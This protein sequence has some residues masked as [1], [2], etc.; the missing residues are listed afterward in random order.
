MI[1]LPNYDDQSFQSIMERATGC[2]PVIYPQWTDLNEHDPGITILELFAWLKEMQQFQLNRISSRS[3]ASLLKLLGVTVRGPVPSETRLGFA[4]FSGELTLLRGA[5]FSTQDVVFEAQA[6][7]DLHS[8]RVEH[9]YMSDGNVFHNVTDMI[10]EPS[11]YCQVFG[12]APLEG[13]SALYIGLNGWAGKQEL[14]LYFQMDDSYPVPR[15]PFREDVLLPREIAWEYGVTGEG[16]LEF[17]VMANVRDETWGFSQSGHVVFSMAQEPAPGSPGEGLPSCCWLR[18][19]LVRQGCEENPRLLNIFTDTLPVVQKETHCEMT[20]YTFDP[21]APEVLCEPDSRLVQE[22]EAMVFVR[23][24]AGWQIHDRVEILPD[25]RGRGRVFKLNLPEGM[26][27][28]GG[29][30]VRILCYEPSFKNAMLL[31]GSDG[32]PCQRFPFR[33]QEALLKEQLRLMV[34]EETEE[35]QRGWTDWSYSHNLTLAGPYDR[36]FTYDS[37]RGELV[38]GDNEHGAV[39][40]AGEDN[41]LITDCAVTK[42]NGGN[43]GYQDFASLDDEA[44]S[45]KPFNLHPVRGGRDEESLQAAL[46]R[47]Q[48]SLKEC[49]RAVTATDYETLAMGTPGRRIMGAKAI[50]FYDPDSKVAGAKQ[51]AATVTVVVVPYSEEPFPQPDQSFLESVRRHLDQYRLITTQVKVIGPS[52]IKIFLDGEILVDGKRREYIEDDVR[53]NIEDYFREL[54]QGSSA[55][56]GKPEF[57]KPVQENTLAV[58]ISQIPGIIYVKKLTLGVKLG[59]SYRDK[60]GTIVIPPYGLPYLGELQIRI[61]I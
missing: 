14:T 5:R 42:G 50:P 11:L 31:P 2:I 48:I 28:D 58:R 32:L 52:Y 3:Y 23:D 30:N 55:Q 37:A 27:M 12:S 6:P 19:R 25:S 15:N 57:G 60:D 46:E 51:T 59:E 39:P 18:V 41:I 34:Y 43:I 61:L 38:F 24:E 20:G 17:Q 36:C 26:A 47:F 35:G 44:F 8:L 7:V 4:G 21:A 10:K 54:G 45:L 56:G 49:T 9:V 53:K 29:E 16:G 1:S 22:G 13:A 33:H 40:L